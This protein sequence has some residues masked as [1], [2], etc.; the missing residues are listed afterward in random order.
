MNI[1]TVDRLS[2]LANE[3]G[4]L[5]NSVN[6]KMPESLVTNSDSFTRLKIKI[7]NLL[8]EELPGSVTIEDAEIMACKI[9]SLFLDKGK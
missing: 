1:E 2:A 3:D 7:N 6:K 4:Y 5:V 8:W 9:M